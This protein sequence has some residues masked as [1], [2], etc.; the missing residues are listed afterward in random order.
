MRSALLERVLIFTHSFISAVVVIFHQHL[1]SNSPHLSSQR[2]HRGFPIYA[3]ACFTKEPYC[4][5][6]SSF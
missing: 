2:V 4:I 3:S 1:T 5:P 6:S